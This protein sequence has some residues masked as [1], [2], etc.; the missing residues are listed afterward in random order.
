MKTPVTDIFR[1]KGAAISRTMLMLYGYAWIAAA[2]C[3]L[4]PMILAGI[5]VDVRWIIV[6]LMAIFI[7]FPM[8]LAFL[9]FYYGLNRVSVINST[10]HSLV[11]DN[12]G[13]SVSIYNKEDGSGA[14]DKSS[15]KGEVS[16]GEEKKPRYELRS[17]TEIP[18]SAVKDYIVGVSDIILRTNLSGKGFLII[19][20]SAFADQS[21]LMQAIE[22]VKCK[23]K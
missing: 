8:L 9:F 13:L 18:Y 11:F 2:G 14:G 17:Q 3:L 1:I 5:F 7:V 4:V 12:D 23:M 19:P 6:T 15:A 16:K 20:L 21:M 22:N 10:L